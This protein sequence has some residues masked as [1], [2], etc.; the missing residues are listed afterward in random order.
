MT[1]STVIF[2]EQVDEPLKIKTATYDST[3]NAWVTFNSKTKK[4]KLR[5]YI[6]DIAVRMQE[7]GCPNYTENRNVLIDAFND[8]NLKG[9]NDYYVKVANNYVK[10]ITNGCSR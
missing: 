5:K 1:E 9:I 10:G 3:K 8:G 7:F 6:S 4:I 2:N